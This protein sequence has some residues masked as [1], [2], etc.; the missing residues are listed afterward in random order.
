MKSEKVQSEGGSKEEGCEGRVAGA[1]DWGLGSG[2]WG[3]GRAWRSWSFATR[4]RWSFATRVQGRMLDLIE[5]DLIHQ[6][7]GMSP[8]SSTQTQTK[9]AKRRMRPMK[10]RWA[11]TFSLGGFPVIP[12]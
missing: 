7:R 6:W 1:R 11:W 8:K 9:S 2:A 12:S 4:V 3:V 10:V 5:L